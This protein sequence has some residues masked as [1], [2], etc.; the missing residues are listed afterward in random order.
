ML[1]QKISTIFTKRSALKPADVY[2]WFLQKKLIDGSPAFPILP[3]K[4]WNFRAPDLIRE[5]FSGGLI[6][7]EPTKIVEKLSVNSR[8][9]SIYKK[10]SSTPLDISIQ[11]VKNSA[12]SERKAV[13]RLFRIFCN[14][15]QTY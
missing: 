8:Y 13:Q 9:N 6:S 11:T 7:K 1:I 2:S 12:P 5:K 14:H 10:L 15:R 3:T 4:P